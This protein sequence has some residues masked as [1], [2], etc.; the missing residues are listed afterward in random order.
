MVQNSLVRYIRQQIRAGYDTASIK[1]YLLKYGY[2]EPDINEALHYAYPPAEVKHVVHPSKTTVALVI[3]VICSVVLISAGIFVFFIGKEPSQLLDVETDLISSSLKSGDDLRFT[4]E[5]FNLGKA[6]RYDVSLRYEIY[7]EEDDRITFKEETIALETRV[8][9]SVSIDLGDIPAGNYYLRT[10]AFYG[11]KEAKATSAFR[12]TGRDIVP[13]PEPEPEPEPDIPVERCPVN[14]DDNNECTNDYC[15]EQTRY[16]CRHDKMYPCCGNGICE[17]DEDYNSCLADCSVPDDR[18][19]DIFEGKTIP[20]KI[21]MIKDIA[22]NDKDGA[23]GYCNGIEQT[24]YRYKCFIGVAVSSNDDELCVNIVD[25]SYKDTC[26]KDF[27]TTNRNS[28]VCAKIVKDSK[29]DQ[30]YMSFVTKEDYTVC[31]KLVNKYLKQSCESLKKLSE[32]N[33]PSQ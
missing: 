14:C 7:N 30:C 16:E 9:S 31:D 6:K 26:Y 33:L 32:V 23:L 17:D 4:A 13:E 28:D 1:A 24:G 21:E 22:K 27:A 5:I 11:D 29:R 3:A 25:E 18:G 20:D 8:S 15:D 2:K 10:T 19:E 12:V